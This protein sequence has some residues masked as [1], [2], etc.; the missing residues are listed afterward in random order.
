MQE[1]NQCCTVLTAHIRVTR[2]ISSLEQFSLP[3]QFRY[4]LKLINKRAIN[5]FLIFYDA[6]QET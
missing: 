2:D 5:L 6:P 4:I 1:I 3:L